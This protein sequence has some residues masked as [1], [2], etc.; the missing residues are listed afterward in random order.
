LLA[1]A[2]GAGVAAVVSA[3]SSKSESAAVGAKVNAG[4]VGDV[5]A[6]LASQ[7]YV[8]SGEGQF[9]LLAAAPDTAIA[10]SWKCTHQGCTVRNPDVQKETMT[11]PCHGTV[12]DARTGIVI[13]GPA[14]RPLDYMPIAITD[15]TVVVDTSRIMK[16]TTFDA[17]QATRLG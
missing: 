17:S 15:G 3:C 16:R 1:V 10:V 5:R 11:C 12:Y 4:S 2:V 13:S 9:F 8:R 7:H 6:S 14:S